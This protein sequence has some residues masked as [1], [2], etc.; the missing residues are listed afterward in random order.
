MSEICMTSSKAA[1]GEQNLFHP[2]ELGGVVRHGATVL[3]RDQHMHLLPER[4]GRGQRLGGG[5]LEGLI[6][7]LGEKKRGHGVV[8]RAVIASTSGQ[9]GRMR[10]SDHPHFVLEL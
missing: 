3:A 5:V 7:V 4:I 9:K 10:P 6:V 2:I 8:I 1:I